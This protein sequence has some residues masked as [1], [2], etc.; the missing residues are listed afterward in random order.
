MEQPTKQSSS[1]LARRA[2]LITSALAMVGSCS[3][4]IGILKGTAAGPERLLILSCLLFTSGTLVI[5]VVCRNIPLQIIATTSTAYFAFYLCACSI[6]AVSNGSQPLNLLIYLVWFF[7]LLVFNKMVNAANVGRR[8]YRGLL[9]APILLLACLYS[10][11]IVVFKIEVLFV[12][13][14]YCLS[15]ISFGMMF[16]VITRYREEYVLERA[17]AESLAELVKTNAELLQAKDRAEAANRA[18]SEFLANISHEIRTPMNGVIGMTD[19][20]LDTAL[21]PEQRDYLTTVKSSAREMLLV[22]N[23]VLDFSK[24]EAGK[25]ELD[26][27]SFNPRAM[28][29]ETCRALALQADAKGLELTNEVKVE[30]PQYLVGDFTRIR[31]ILV[32]LLGNAIKFTELGQVELQVALQSRSA[33]QLRLHFSIRDTG[34][35]IS[36]DKQKLIFEAFSQ[37][38]GSTNRRFGGTG[39]GLAICA[40]LVDLMRG[41]IWVESAPK[42]GSCFHFTVMLSVVSEIQHV[43][44]LAEATP[45]SVRSTELQ[46]SQS[47][48]PLRIL[49]VEDNA[50][51]Q[52]VAQRI[53]EKAGHFVVIAENGRAALSR[54]EQRPFDLILMDVQMPE[55]DGIE[56]T[57]HIRAQ[58][59]RTGVHM[60][61]IAMTAHAMEGDRERCLQAGMDGYLSK[62]VAA[63][64]L[65][66]MMAEFGA[67]DGAS[68][69]T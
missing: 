66:D 34:I 19:L 28:V 54:L 33:D 9:A 59:K 29:E 4:V 67:P 17:R 18:K 56:A 24:V 35:G 27:V 41:E 51:N 25:L 37:A 30:V 7:P 62:P 32:N 21:N 13:V 2:L 43:S 6:S 8:L 55:M 47:F 39:L 31:Q 58:E 64:A 15:Y 46:T 22:I 42:K 52:R 12:L 36:P 23:D 45:L 65:L 3:G 14:A 38:D 44:S 26:P 11:L 50:V 61:I 48:D 69:P 5:L 68:R 60:P 49:L 10:R 57:A 16:D 40:R 63:S 53:L 20:V 1:A